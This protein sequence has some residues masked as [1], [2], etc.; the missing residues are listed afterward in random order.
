M[1]SRKA[2]AEDKHTTT[3]VKQS[4]AKHSPSVLRHSEPINGDHTTPFTERLIPLSLE[5]LKSPKVYPTDLTA[6]ANMLKSEYCSKVST[7]SVCIYLFLCQR[8]SSFS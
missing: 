7:G 4:R 6:T 2:M 1:S 8:Y 3:S 5:Q